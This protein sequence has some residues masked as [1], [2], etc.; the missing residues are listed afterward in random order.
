MHSPRSCRR[1]CAAVR[2]RALTSSRRA[3]RSASELAAI[4]PP[5]TL[6]EEGRPPPLDYFPPAVAR[7]MRGVQLFL[8][9]FEGE[10]ADS[11]GTDGRRRRHGRERWRVRRH[12]A[13]RARAC[14]DFA[15][16]ERGDVLVARF[17]SPAYN[18][19]LPLLGAIVTERGGLL[20]HAAIVAREYGIPA[21]RRHA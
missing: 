14:R 3:P 16:I 5:V 1:C 20:S 8:T 15:K 9:T 18:V 17:T 13:R 2:H 6:G 4:D 12:G 19:L 21:H 7:M 10:R 11:H